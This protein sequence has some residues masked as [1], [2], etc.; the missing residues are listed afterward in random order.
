M[1]SHPVAAPVSVTLCRL[2]T[3]LALSPMTPLVAVNGN[4]AA[5]SCFLRPH[6]SVGWPGMSNPSAKTFRNYH[7]GADQQMPVAV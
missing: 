3:P 5:V 4:L 2:V 7:P 1:P 6:V